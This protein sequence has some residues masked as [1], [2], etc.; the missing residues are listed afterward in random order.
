[1][2]AGQ[3]GA[4]ANFTLYPTFPVAGA[5]QRGGTGEADAA[6]GFLFPDE[7]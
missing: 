4:D 7:A 6:L 5:W 1:M 2:Q 3:A